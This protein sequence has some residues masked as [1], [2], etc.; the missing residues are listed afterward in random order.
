MK[1]CSRS[2]D[3]G[4]RAGMS[5]FQQKCLHLPRSGGTVLGAQTAMQADVLV[6]DHDAAAE[7]VSGDVEILVEV[8][9]RRLEPSAQIPFLSVLGESDAIGRADR[10]ARLAFDTQR[11]IE[12]RLKIAIETSP[13]LCNSLRDIEAE[14]DLGMNVRKRLS[15]RPQRHRQSGGRPRRSE[16][17]VPPLACFG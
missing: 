2:R 14:F 9:R 4:R 12:H 11:R 17:G 1:C 6:L 16:C 13:G 5:Q 8:G 3:R 7:E 15:L 10:L